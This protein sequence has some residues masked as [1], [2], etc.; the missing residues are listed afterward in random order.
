MKLKEAQA[1][2][3]EEL[4]KNNNPRTF[5][6]HVNSNFYIVQIGLLAKSHYCYCV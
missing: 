1:K 2:R 4:E 3:V 5:N 6:L